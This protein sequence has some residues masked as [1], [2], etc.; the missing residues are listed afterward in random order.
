[1][2]RTERQIVQDLQRAADRQQQVNREA[3]TRATLAG[4]EPDEPAAAD[5]GDVSA[6]TTPTGKT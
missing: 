1:M 2:A 6:A 3:K 5:L 4:S